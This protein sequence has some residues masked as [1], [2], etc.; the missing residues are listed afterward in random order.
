MKLY[1]IKFTQDTGNTEQELGIPAKNLVDAYIQVQINFPKA[2][3]TGVR[4]SGK[5]LTFGTSNWLDILAKHLVDHATVEQVREVAKLC[6]SDMR[7]ELNDAIWK[8][9]KSK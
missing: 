8:L 4:D 7:E 3:I 6:D 9:K 1:F 5:M 2:E